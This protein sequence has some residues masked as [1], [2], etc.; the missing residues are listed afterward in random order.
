MF[1]ALNKTVGN[2]LCLDGARTGLELLL[3]TNLE[4]HV[5]VTVSPCS[6]IGTLSPWAAAT[7]SAST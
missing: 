1:N 3:R 6:C 4:F 7:S 2:E 5:V